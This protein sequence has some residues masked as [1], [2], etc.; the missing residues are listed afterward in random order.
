MGHAPTRIKAGRNPGNRLPQITRCGP[1]P[2]PVQSDA[3]IPAQKA[4]RSFA[5]G[6]DLQ[7]ASVVGAA[8]SLRNFLP[9]PEYSAGR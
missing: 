5:L 8:T 6:E 9:P 3:R 1:K 4:R 7:N 2:V